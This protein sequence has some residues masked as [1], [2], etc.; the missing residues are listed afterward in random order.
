MAAVSAAFCA[1]VSRVALFMGRGFLPIKAPGSVFAALP[2]AV[3][4]GT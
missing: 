4:L 2:G 3:L 1:V